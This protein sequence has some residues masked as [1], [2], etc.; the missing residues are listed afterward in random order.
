MVQVPDVAAL[1]AKGY[2][3]A[4]LNY[5]LGTSMRAAALTAIQDGKAAVRFLRANA[6]RY[7]LDRN[8]FAVW[9]NSAGGYMAAMLGVTGDQPTVFDDPALGNPSVSSAVQAVVVWFGAEDRLPAPEFR[10]STYLPTAKILPVFLIANGDADPVISATRAKR[11][12]D[13]LIRAGAR[14]TLTILP[15]AGHEDPV[16][17][18]TQMAP[19]FLF[20][21]KAF[22]R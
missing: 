13:A 8:R 2:A 10:I 15:G 16:F 7:G 12:H 21:D 19:T 5:R 3:V 18:A 6:S 4:S 11:L 20:L 9:G 17:M 14:S 22:G 1:M